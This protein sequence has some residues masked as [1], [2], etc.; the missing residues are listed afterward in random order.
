MTGVDSNSP[1]IARPL[2]SKATGSLAKVAQSMGEDIVPVGQTG[3]K[4]QQTASNNATTGGKT[5]KV[6]PGDNLAKIAAKTMGAPSKANIA[7]II[8]A[9]ASL[10]QNPNLIIAGH[11]YN[12]PVGGNSAAPASSNGTSQ[13]SKSAPQ[14]IAVTSDAPAS[15]TTSDGGSI[16]IVKPLD[17]LT[18]IA[19]TQ[20]GSASAVEAIRDLNQDVLK[21]GDVIQPNMK[22]RLPTKP[23]TASAT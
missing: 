17:S 8:A 22:L 6:E 13:S 20:L 12:I 16:Y 2:D 7:A 3:T 4:P 21:G 10:Q 14:S 1:A 18:K 15:S 9:N 11:T 19:V 23:A 5:Y